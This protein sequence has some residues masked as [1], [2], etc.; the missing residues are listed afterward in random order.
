MLSGCVMAILHCGSV[1]ACVT[2]K[3]EITGLIPDWAEFAVNAVLLGRA[4]IRVCT[5]L[6]Q[7]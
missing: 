6:T 4:I 3:R 7:E 2:C 1:V 5:L